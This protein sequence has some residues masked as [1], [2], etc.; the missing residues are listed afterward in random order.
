MI[1]FVEY[2]EWIKN[3]LKSNWF[4]CVPLVETNSC[5]CLACLD[6]FRPK[7]CVRKI[8]K[9]VVFQFFIGH[10][11]FLPLSMPWEWIERLMSSLILCFYPTMVSIAWIKALR[12]KKLHFCFWLLHWL[13][14]MI[15]CS[16]NVGIRHKSWMVSLASTLWEQKSSVAISECLIG[17]IW[18]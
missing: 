9:K 14:K 17:C 15:A 11:V 12:A 1:V 6:D 10:G 4:P 8:P 7:Y 2:P 3:V 13:F 18:I 16:S 5:V